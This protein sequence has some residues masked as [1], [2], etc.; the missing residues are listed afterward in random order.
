[1]RIIVNAI[2]VNTG[3]IVT[4]TTNLIENISAEHVEMIVYV[5]E[6][7]DRSHFEGLDVEVVPV[8]KR[9]FGP[10][11]RFLWEQ[12]GWRRIIKESG[13]DLVFSSANYGVLF[14][15]IP[16]VLLVQG[17]IYLNPVYREK[18][19]PH[20]SWREQ[21]SAYLRRNLMLLSARHSRTTIF[22]SQVAL[23]SARQFDWRLDENSVVNYLGV[24]PRFKEAGHRRKWRADGTIRLLYVSVY[25]PHKDP[26]TLANATSELNQRGIPVVTRITMEAHDFD[27]WDTAAHELEELRDPKFADCLEMGR[28]EHDELGNVLSD[29]DAFVFPSMAE[30]FGFPMVEAMQ[31]GVP[32]LVS[33]IPVH[34]EICDDAAL[35]FELGNPKDLADKI[36]ELDGDPALRDQLVLK[37]RERAGTKFTW[38]KHVHGL[39]AEMVSIVDRKRFRLLINAL[40][41]RSGGGITYL[42][43]MLPLLAKDAGLD[44]HVC[45]HEDQRELLPTT[46]SGIRFHFQRYT[47]GFWRVLFREQIDIPRLARRLNM[48]ATFS[49]ANYGPFLSRNHIVLIRNAVSVGF[50]ERRPIKLAYWMLLYLATLFSLVTSRRAIAV[51]E[52]AKRGIQ[53]A[54][55]NVIGKQ[56]VVVPHGVDSRFADK[57]SGLARETF[58][59]SVSDIY[60]QKNFTGLI[61]VVARL[62]DRYP[63]I[64]LKVAGNPVDQDY[65]ESLK[66]LIQ[67]EKL[68]AHVEFL[69]H[70]QP[71]EL[72]VLY[73]RCGVFV[74]PSTVETFG[75]PLVEA[76]AC[77][78]PIAS[79]NSAAMPEV[80]GDA[81]VFFDPNDIDEMYSVISDLIS[82]PDKRRELSLKAKERSTMYS[83]DKTKQRT[84]DVITESA[85]SGAG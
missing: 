79:S 67:K 40:H 46:L 68:E 81:A 26:G 30:T 45:L 55:W 78:A 49:P 57:T 54:F 7:F 29:Y 35:Y 11:H 5:P 65:F 52:Y 44:V 27:A 32:L 4:Y 38:A 73:E 13:A 17:E 23:E 25:Y 72:Q 62:R 47:R 31:A 18:V 63:D 33:D 48:D 71:D 37:G 80:L 2:S 15:P 10:V 34:R 43:N 59:L 39:L 16:Q 70:V 19:L 3:G 75:N 60:V 53:G 56:L 1:M 85:P 82:D 20:L 61:N 41:A 51:S 21:L 77:G 24:S 58:L 28:I 6:W 83:W 36:E 9:F 66:L 50:V 42:R 64:R 12:L 22:P 84:I 74:F 69:G 8:K 14:P 76:M